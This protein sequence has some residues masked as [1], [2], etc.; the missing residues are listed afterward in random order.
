[1]WRIMKS[2]IIKFDY[3]KKGHRPDVVNQC[4][5]CGE[6]SASHFIICPIC[7]SK[8]IKKKQVHFNTFNLLEKQF[9]VILISRSE[10]KNRFIPGETVDNL[11]DD[12]LLEITNIIAEMVDRAWPDYCLRAIERI[13]K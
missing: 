3:D 6:L 9:P 13:K 11:T 7:K 12:Q 4:Q 1:M 2:K 5:N 10:L 8:V